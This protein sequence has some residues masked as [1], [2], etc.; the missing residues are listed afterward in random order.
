MS[1]PS[2]T[3]RNTGFRVAANRYGRY[4]VP[5]P[6]SWRPAS[7]CVLQGAVWEEKTI[8]FVR[9]HAGL[10]DI[11]HAGAFFGDFLP[12][13][14]QALAPGCTLWAFEPNPDNYSAASETC[15]LNALDNVI[16]HNAALGSKKGVAT[17][18][19]RE[20]GRAI[21]GMSAIVEKMTAPFD[22]HISVPVERI[23]DV[24]SNRHISIIHLDI[25]G[26]EEPA[27]EGA[28]QTICQC[29]P[30]IILETVPAEWCRAR[31][32]RSDI[33]TEE[34]WMRTQFSAP[35]RFGSTPAH[36]YAVSNREPQRFCPGSGQVVNCRRMTPI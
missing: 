6:S 35:W 11:I 34:L 2:E 33:R 7:Q 3:M 16:L 36:F 17:M 18:K 30:I 4:C 20:G 28:L 19:V 13:L 8:E 10:G 26:Y 22:D 9:N 29:R 5:D 32:A 12:A 25:E 15:R 21:G 24:V 27:L 31:L 14:S 1:D 23:D